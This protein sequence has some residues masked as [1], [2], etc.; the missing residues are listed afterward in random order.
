MQS[1][2][3]ND[4][5][6]KPFFYEKLYHN[7]HHNHKIN[8]YDL[9]LIFSMIFSMKAKL[10]LPIDFLFYE[11]ELF[12]YIIIIFYLHHSYHYIT[13]NHITHFFSFKKKNLYINSL[14]VEKL[15]AD[16]MHKL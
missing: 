9:F 8:Y 6:P 11:I 2:L 14:S 7:D 1:L 12:F 4:D 5:L 16:P 15:T 13:I 10:I 3:R